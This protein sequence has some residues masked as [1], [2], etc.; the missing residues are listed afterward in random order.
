MKSQICKLGARCLA[1][2]LFEGHNLQSSGLGLEPGRVIE[3]RFCGQAPFDVVERTS[4]LEGAK[5]V[6]KVR[7][8]M[9]AG[10]DK[11]ISHGGLNDFEIL[12]I[13]LASPKNHLLDRRFGKE[14]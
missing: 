1:G 10:F 7:F 9:A 5:D 11:H 12:K 13:S 2:Q 4:F 8:S 6:F 3:V 14:P